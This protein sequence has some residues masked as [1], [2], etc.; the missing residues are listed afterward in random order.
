MGSACCRAARSRPLCG[1]GTGRRVG[2]GA[3]VG[4]GVGV[5]VG[6]GVG[7]GDGV[8]VGGG[9]VTVTVGPSSG[10]GCGLAE[11]VAWNVTCQVP[12]GSFDVPCQV[13]ACVLPLATRSSGIVTPP[14]SAQTAWAFRTGLD[15][16]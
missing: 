10:A 16:L 15:E 12:T 6:G 8:G 5:G 13:P 2:V 1:V 3:A 4:R 11:V 9:I 14:T 7:V